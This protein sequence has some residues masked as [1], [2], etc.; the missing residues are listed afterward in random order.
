MATP[1]SSL[2]SYASA[3]DMLDHYDLRTV[4]DLISD[5]GTRT[6]GSPNPTRSTV[7]ASPILVKILKSAAGW[8]EAACLR[9]QR[10]SPTDLQALD[11]VSKEMLIQLNCDLAMGLLFRRRPDK[12]A[13]PWSFTAALQVLESLANGDRIFSFVEN[14]EAGLPSEYVMSPADWEEI[15]MVPQQAR[16]YYGVRADQLNQSGSGSTGSLPN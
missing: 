16:R 12:S 9:S 4:A 6:G 13:P 2:T 8:I 10:Y 11:G 15:A 3:S 5:N 7:E 14:E 1:N